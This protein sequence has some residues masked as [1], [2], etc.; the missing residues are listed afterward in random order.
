MRALVTGGNGF[1]GSHLVRR[2]EASGHSVRVMAQPGTSLGP[3]DGTAAEVVNAD[4][5]EPESLRAAL[6][7]VDTVFHLAGMVGDW[8]RPEDFEKINALGTRSLIEA[9]EAAGARRVVLVSSVAIHSLRNGGISDGRED[10]PRDNAELPYALSKIH[11]EDALREAHDA[12]RVEGVVVRPGLFPFGPED[13]TSFLP[14]VQKLGAYAHVAGGRA[15]LSTAYVENLAH[16]IA[17]AGEVEGAAGRTY[18]IADG[19]RITWRELMDRICDELGRERVRRAIPFAAA[20]AAACV[21][22]D[23]S[24]LLGRAPLLTRYRVMVASRDSYFDPARARRE[25]GYEPVVDLEEGIRRTVAWVR[26][27]I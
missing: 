1:I 24:R 26:T 2:L 4:L 7:G 8:G 14:L 17:L 27:Q 3:I 23:L 20:W 10:L 13:R 21:V 25:L 15:I 6:P 12:G 11:A 18:I 9:A 16:G 22:E 5:T 19:V